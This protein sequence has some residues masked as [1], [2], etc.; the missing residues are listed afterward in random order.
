MTGLAFS[1]YNAGMSR[2]EDKAKR[3]QLGLRAI[4]YLVTVLTVCALTMWGGQGGA[5]I[6]F[7][8]F[9]GLAA[10]DALAALT[11]DSDS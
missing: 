3:R 4:G 5:I 11:A 1:R 6:A 2:G 10:L 7:V 8:I 9:I